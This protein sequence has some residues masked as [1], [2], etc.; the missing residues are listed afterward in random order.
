[1]TDVEALTAALAAE[2]AAVFGYGAAGAR[3]PEPRRAR[4]RSAYQAH[5][6]RRDEL[7]ALLADAGADVA[8]AAPAYELPRPVRTPADAVAV[9]LTIEERAAV[10]YAAM[11]GATTGQVRGLAARALQEAAV[12]AA[13][14]RGGSVPFPGLPR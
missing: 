8:P 7:V 10:T 5:L 13:E 11:V 12:R 2:H 4:A 9:L 1:V 3:L 14:W 6:A